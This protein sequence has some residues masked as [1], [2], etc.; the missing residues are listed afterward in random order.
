MDNVIAREIVLWLTF[1]E[2]KG[3]GNKRLDV[4]RIERLGVKK[5][6]KT[7]IND[8]NDGQEVDVSL[9]RENE[10]GLNRLNILE[11]DRDV[12]RKDFRANE[13]ARETTII[14]ITI[15]EKVWVGTS[16]VLHLRVGE[17]HTKGTTIVN[18][19]VRLVLEDSRGT[20]IVRREKKSKRI[21]GG[22][23]KSL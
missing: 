17:V 11:V 21:N 18:K 16:D 19:K 14:G 2:K 13:M 7:L 8:I 1:L 9:F 23:E 5:V 12:A 3:E 20:T 6:S 22:N 10:D 4:G 15:V